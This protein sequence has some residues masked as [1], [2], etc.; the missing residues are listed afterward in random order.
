MTGQHRSEQDSARTLTELVQRARSHLSA[1]HWDYLMGAAETE[2]ALHRNRAGLNAL[3][4]RPR[5]LNDVASVRADSQ[6]LDQRLRIPVLLAPLGSIQ[7]FA[8]DGAAAAARA[9][10]RFGVPH[11]LSSV[12]LPDYEELAA[13]VPG[14]RFLQLYLVGDQAWLDAVIERAIALGYSGLCLTADT[15]VYSRRERDMHRRWTPP[16]G[17]VAGG[18]DFAFQSRMSWDTVAHIK[19]RFDLPLIIKGVNAAEDAQRCVDSGVD[20][21]YVSD[22]GGRQLDHTRPCID[23]LADVVP[24]VNGAVPVVVDGGFYRGADVVKALCLGANAVGLGRL[25]GLALAAGGTPGLVRMLE[26][27][28]HEIT[29]TMALLGAASLEQLQ[30]ELLVSSVP[31]DAGDLDSAFPLLRDGL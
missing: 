4:F 6:L 26:I 22:H 16:S 31:L 21:I 27:L 25:Q 24:A 2:T 11:M 9:A 23:A 30:P 8:A 14:P 13:M 3:S 5:I 20:V 1:A 19:D 7:L 18:E 28:E 12:C 15:Q 10:A 17:R 29:T